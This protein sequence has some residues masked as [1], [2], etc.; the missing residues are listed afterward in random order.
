LVVGVSFCVLEFSYGVL[1]V[2]DV[3]GFGESLPEPF[4]DGL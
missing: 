1:E 3:F 2:L 4:L